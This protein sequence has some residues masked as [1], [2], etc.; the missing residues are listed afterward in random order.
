MTGLLFVLVYQIIPSE[1]LA[2]SLTITY[3]PKLII[4]PKESR[5]D[6]FCNYS[7]NP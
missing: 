6:R 3:E 2:S 5:F 7:L 4:Q 1:M